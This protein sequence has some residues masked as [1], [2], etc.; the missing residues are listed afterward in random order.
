MDVVDQCPDHEL[1]PLASP[2]QI[3]ALTRPDVGDQM[4]EPS[5]E[6]LVTETVVELGDELGEFIAFLRV[7]SNRVCEDLVNPVGVFESMG[8]MPSA[9]E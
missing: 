3:A 4:V 2:R 1:A 9:V 6:E 7:R 8:V 5:E